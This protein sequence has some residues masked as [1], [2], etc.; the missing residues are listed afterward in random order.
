VDT[1]AF[2]L[3]LQ[4]NKK[5]QKELAGKFTE[6]YEIGDCN[7]PHLIADAIAAGSKI[8]HSI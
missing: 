7:E 3:P 6:V 5:L 2:A 4:S 8:G 1:V